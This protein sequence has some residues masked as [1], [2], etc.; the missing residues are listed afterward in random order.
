MLRQAFTCACETCACRDCIHQSRG[1]PLFA[2]YLNI[3]LYQ[4][5]H[6]GSPCVSNTV[7]AKCSFAN[8][9]CTSPTIA[10]TCQLQH[11]RVCR[12]ALDRVTARSSLRT[13]SSSGYGF[14]P[15][16]RRPRPVMERLPLPRR[17]RVCVQEEI[18]LPELCTVSFT[19]HHL[20]SPPHPGFFAGCPSSPK[21]VLTALAAH[22]PLDVQLVWRRGPRTGMC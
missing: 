7:L 20:L 10:P 19:T 18:C 12:G 3:R 2:S 5:V 4:K 6:K 8:F 9:S 22:T 14:T 11:V 15:C 17:L 16:P 21:S 13:A 1:N